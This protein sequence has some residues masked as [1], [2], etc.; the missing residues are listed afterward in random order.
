MQLPKIDVQRDSLAS[1]LMNMK[2]G[3]LQVPRFQR[4]FVWPLTKTRA[5]LDSMYKEFPIGTFFLWRAPEGSP[6]LS[7]PLDE[8]GIPGPQPGA[9][10]SYILDGQQRLSSLYCAVHG[11]RFGARD[12]G[13]ICI[14]LETAT[15][16]DM[17]KDEDFTDDLFV[18]RTSDKRQFISVQ[19]L[20][21]QNT[22]QIYENVP[23]EWK[24]AFTKIHNMFQTYPFSVV[25]IQEQTLADAIIIFQRINQSGKPLSRFDLVCANVWREDFDFR[26]QVIDI[27]KELA[28][29]GFGQIEETIFTQAFALIQGDQCTTVA[30]L[31]LTTEQI[32]ANWTKVIRSIYLAVDFVSNNLGVKRFD[33]L[34]YRGQLVVL[35]YYFYHHKDS[36]LSV[37]ERN[38][39]WDWFWRVTLSERYSATS[40]AKMAEDARKMRAFMNGEE[41]SFNFPSAVTAEAILKTKMSSTSSALRN[42]V[43]CL[44]ALKRPL[45]FKDN[46]PVNLGDSFFTNIKQAE[47]HHIFPVGHLRDLGMDANRVHLL[48]NFCFIPGD[49]NKE[50]GSHPPA[51]Y[52]QVYKKE[53]PMFREAANSHLLPVDPKSSIW[54][55]NATAFNHFL[56]E[57]AELLAKELGKLLEKGPMYAQQGHWEGLTEVDLMEIRLRD[58]ID[59]R[60]VAS[61][62]EDYWSKAIPPKVLS[63]MQKFTASSLANTEPE[64]YSNGRRQLDFCGIAH[65]EKIIT[66]NWNVFEEYLQSQE[67]FER[68]MTAFR[69]LRNAVQHN[70]KP[71]PSEQE[72]GEAAIVWL[73]EMLDR[74]E[75]ILITA[76]S[77]ENGDEP[78]EE[79]NVGAT[80]S[81]PRGTNK[82]DATA[83]GI[84]VTDQ[85]KRKAMFHIIKSLCDHGIKPETIASLIHW[86]SSTVFFEVDGKYAQE[87]FIKAA[88]AKLKVT[89]KTF[90]PGRWFYKD[91]KL[92]VQDGKTYA[93]ST[94]WGML[95]LQAV[96]ILKRTFPEANIE[97]QVS[98]SDS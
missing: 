2:N 28:R 91:G 89:G 36:N 76:H 1:I 29:R 23:P 81:V 10:V 58:F 87:D 63:D 26:K 68:H 40:P 38:M 60:L 83:Y 32:K 33:Y 66:A 84:S 19:D 11:I 75:M 45:N 37:E 47:R 8:L 74:Y 41:A 62:G 21:G 93:I 95:T 20:A 64:S 6:P 34:P 46:S 79:Q 5:L 85:P 56:A 7:R 35:A 39:L 22:L 42:G 17:N 71:S 16:F 43:L 48:P 49:L 51:D 55:N 18:Y 80:G 78:L 69:L 65:Y 90:D 96:N 31:S 59:E 61:V 4:D 53:N 15:R 72:D 25:W 73:K 92:V 50:I 12:Y 67:D 57:R 27:N 9:K 86:R 30:E 44:L 70:R 98:Q 94:Q 52:M 54:K 14:D 13:R 82:Y 3:A 24:P 77:Q 88:S 97:C